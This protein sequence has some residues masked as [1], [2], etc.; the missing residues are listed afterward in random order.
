MTESID[1]IT[2]NRVISEAKKLARQYRQ[3]TGK[4][5]GIT[6][7]I[8]EITAAE[9]FN[10]KLTEAR[11]PGFDAMAQDGRRIQIKS[12]CVKPKSSQRVGRINLNHDFDTVML[13]LMDED[14]EPLN[15]YEAMREDV[16]RELQVPGSKSRN[17]RGALGVR[18]FV[19]ISSQIW[20]REDRETKNPYISCSNLE[21]ITDTLMDFADSIATEDLLPT[22]V[23]EA[24]NVVASDPY[25]F[26]V[27]VCLDR[28]TK[29]EIIWTIPYD[30]QTELGHLD[31]NK[32]NNMPLEELN[33]S[34]CCSSPPSP[35]CD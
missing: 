21:E 4:P 30:I 16:E 26:A 15:V 34:I 14:Y 35:L 5:L 25:A 3:I 13:V 27:S 17:V 6:G 18:K 8:G 11:H 12:R 31:P 7:E 32:I 23:P 19:S 24:A 9:L 20:S 1:Q 2:L 10:L 29:A 22:V 33:K 28:G